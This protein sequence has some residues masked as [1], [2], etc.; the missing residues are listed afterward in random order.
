[1]SVCAYME[2][3]KMCYVESCPGKRNDV[4]VSVQMLKFLKPFAT[5]GWILG[6]K[7]KSLGCLLLLLIACSVSLGEVPFSGPQFSHMSSEHIQWN[8][9]FTIVFCSPSL[10]QSFFLWSPAP[11]VG[12]LNIFHSFS[13]IFPSPLFPVDFHWQQYYYGIIFQKDRIMISLVIWRST[14]GWIVSPYSRL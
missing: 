1:M 4:Q 12:Q 6:W 8:K 2:I 3:W 5:S 13:F 14:L 10:L 11:H 9:A 7:S